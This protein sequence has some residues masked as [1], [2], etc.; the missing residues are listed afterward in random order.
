[1]WAENAPFAM[2]AEYYG[3]NNEH[4]VNWLRLQTSYYLGAED[5]SSTIRLDD[6]QQQTNLLRAATRGS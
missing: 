6:P 5:G 2:F 4:H 1:M 3:G